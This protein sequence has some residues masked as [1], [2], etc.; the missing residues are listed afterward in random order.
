[1]KQLLFLVEAAHVI[2]LK[3]QLLHYSKKL[4]DHWIGEEVD[5]SR[6]VKGI[7]PK[8][9]LIPQGIKYEHKHNC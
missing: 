6:Q 5:F 2:L 8:A 9:T 4:L 7:L 1:M 3:N